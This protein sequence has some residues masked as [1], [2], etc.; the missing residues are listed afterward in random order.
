MIREI[1]VFAAVCAII[2]VTAV[3][4]ILTVKTLHAAA[5][6]PPDQLASLNTRTMLCDRRNQLD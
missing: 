6:Y 5:D 4:L 3:V 2:A 1:G